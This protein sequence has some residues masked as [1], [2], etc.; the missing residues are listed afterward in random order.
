MKNLITICGLPRSGSTLLQNVLSENPDFFVSKLTS[1]IPGYLEAT[2]LSWSNSQET[3]GAMKAYPDLSQ[4][5]ERVLRGIVDNFYG[6]DK[7]IVDKSRGWTDKIPLAKQLWPESKHLVCIRDPRDILVSCEKLDLKDQTVTKMRS[8]HNGILDRAQALFHKTGM[9]GSCLHATMD[10]V[11]RSQDVHYVKFEDFVTRPRL[12]LA[13]IYDYL[14]LP[15]FTHDINNVPQYA[16]DLD[17]IYFRKFT[18]VASGKIEPPSKNWE[19]FLHPDIAKLVVNAYPDFY[20]T[21]YQD[22]M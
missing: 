9:V 22:R 8:P 5:F 16:Q 7:I 21:F 18:H 10:T 12:I 11:F 4:R 14:E 6:S 20:K 17:E 2:R 19:D 15:Q 13:E 1:N 3:P